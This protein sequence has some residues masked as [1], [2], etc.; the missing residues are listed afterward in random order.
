M[1]SN[2]FYSH[3]PSETDL[4][5][6]HSTQSSPLKPMFLAG[7]HDAEEEIAYVR[8][9]DIQL[10]RSIR[11]LRVV[12]RILA[13]GLSLAAL[14]PITMTLVKFLQTK[15]IYKDV[16]M[17]NG[18][19][20]NRTA[21]AKD[22]KAWPT[23]M[24]FST[25]AMSF[26]LNLGTLIGYFWGTKAANYVSTVGSAFNYTI[27][28]ANLIVWIVVAGIYKYEKQILTDGLHKDLWGWSCSAAA[29][30]LQHAFVD[31]VPFNKYCT[32]QSGS[33]YAGL[34]HVGVVI[35]GVVITLMTGRRRTTKAAIKRRTREHEGQFGAME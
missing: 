9:D 26:I 23:Y 14:I 7:R 4:A 29:D 24:Y 33:W 5:A 28:V 34:V 25:A 2:S 17:A 30:A 1:A 18:T 20:V 15:N 13:T 12:Q 10:K 21:W 8:R 27:L 6:P 11:I 19:T 35:L 16:H 3:L 22:T 31:E 32:V